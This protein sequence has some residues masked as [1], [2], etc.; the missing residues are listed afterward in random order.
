MIFLPRG[1]GVGAYERPV[2]EAY[3]VLDGCVSVGWEEKGETSWKR[4]GSRDLILNPAGQ[5]RRF[6]NDGLT[7]AQF[8]MG[9]GSP[10][11]SGV[12]FR[13]A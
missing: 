13:A 10:D 8:M 3:L 5:A 11:N 12:D 6:R 2:E 1:A 9:T 7:D 4:L